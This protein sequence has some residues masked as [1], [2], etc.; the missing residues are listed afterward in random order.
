MKINYK[1]YEVNYF[2]SRARA[3]KK[4]KKKDKA[5]ALASGEVNVKIVTFLLQLWHQTVKHAKRSENHER[6]LYGFSSFV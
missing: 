3:Q 5:N 1:Q 6:Q 2:K 4:K